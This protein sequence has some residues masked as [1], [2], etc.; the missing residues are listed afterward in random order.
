MS[1]TSLGFCTFAINFYHVWLKSLLRVI[2]NLLY[3]Y[4]YVLLSP[5]RLIV[6][7]IRLCASSTCNG[8]FWDTNKDYDRFHSVQYDQG[9]EILAEISVM[10]KTKSFFIIGSAIFC[11]ILQ[12]FT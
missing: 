1:R 12:L 11:L 3:H 2:Y 7:A 6:I 5:R 9:I 10:P 4:K 8:S